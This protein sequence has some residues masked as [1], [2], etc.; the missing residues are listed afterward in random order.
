MLMTPSA[1]THLR[2]ID[3][4]L[5]PGYRYAEPARLLSE[6]YALALA[7]ADDTGSREL[8]RDC[9]DSALQIERYLLDTLS[10]LRVS[11]C[12]VEARFEDLRVE[13]PHWPQSISSDAWGR[14]IGTR[15][16]SDITDVV[17]G[18]GDYWEAIRVALLDEFEPPRGSPTWSP[19]TLYLAFDELDWK[20]VSALAQKL[21]QTD[22]AA[23]GAILERVKARTDDRFGMVVW[24]VQDVLD[25]VARA[26][27]PDRD[28]LEETSWEEAGVTRDWVEDVMMTASSQL[29]DRMTERG[30]DV[31]EDLV[32]DA[33][34]RED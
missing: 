15:L 14:L 32:S 22:A 23:L 30:W 27:D 4:H 25:A 13:H 6:A 11:K 12:D 17:C 28:Y 3:A 1:Q 7:V 21:P 33:L 34:Q 24:S 16:L 18:G 19:N 29:T 9:L 5:N 20:E 2:D 26:K 10:D 31:L 8:K